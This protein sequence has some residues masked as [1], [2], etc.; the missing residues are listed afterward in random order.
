MTKSNVDD[1]VEV[2]A[3]HLWLEIFSPEC[4]IDWRGCVAE[5]EEYGANSAAAQQVARWRAQS[6]RLAA[7]IRASLPSPPPAEDLAGQG[8]PVA[9]RIGN[10]YG[11]HVYEGDRPVATFHS[12]DDAARAVAA[13]N[14]APA[15]SRPAD[16]EEIGD[17]IFDHVFGHLK[18]GGSYIDDA[19]SAAGVILERLAL[20]DAPRDAGDGTQETIPSA[21]ADQDPCDCKIG[22]CV[23]HYTR[24]REETKA[25]KASDGGTR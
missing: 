13:V 8:E 25:Q 4:R 21:F 10:H 12:A 2:I 15:P 14:A 3:A 17:I 6:S 9:W 16:R 19:R 18:R 23:K 24:C 7:A 1:L 22:Q 11:I 5:A 20:R